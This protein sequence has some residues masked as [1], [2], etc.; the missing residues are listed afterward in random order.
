MS[1][2]NRKFSDPEFLPI[3]ESIARDDEG[4]SFAYLDSGAH[5][6]RW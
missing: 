6:A 1:I 2:L 3:P 5:V 4:T